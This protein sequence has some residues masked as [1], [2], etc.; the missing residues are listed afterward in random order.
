M[1]KNKYYAVKVGKEPGIYKTWDFCKEQVEGYSG[2]EYKSFKTKAEA[3][4]YLRGEPIDTR[5][6]ISSQKA[7]EEEID[8]SWL[9]ENELIAYVDGSY[10]DEDKSFSYGLLL[11]GK[12]IDEKYSQRFQNKEL[13]TMRNVAG[14]LKGALMAMKRSIELNKHKLYM[15]YDYAGI[16]NWA[17]GTWKTNKIGTMMYKQYVDQ[18]ADILQLEF[19]KV[20]AH[21]G[22]VG[23]EIVDSLAKEAE[24]E[25]YVEL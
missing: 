10:R 14:E 9:K 23:N 3:E 21:S 17:T 12:D 5:E 16:E 1:A 13:A 22:D 20:E 25:L 24:F 8:I 18:I 11:L 4:A 6:K 7:L 15:Y 2:A 19:I